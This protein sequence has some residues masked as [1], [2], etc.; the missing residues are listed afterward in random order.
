MFQSISLSVGIFVLSIAILV[1][2]QISNGAFDIQNIKEL[3]YENNI[4]LLFILTVSSISL[5]FYNSDESYKKKSKNK[6][7]ITTFKLIAKIIH[8]ST[9]I[10]V[11]DSILIDNFLNLEFHD[12]IIYTYIFISI[13]FWI[14][15]IINDFIM[16]QF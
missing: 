12:N 16:F 4:I 6:L 1:G 13:L 5:Y 8:I 11:V 2:Y 14:K 7:S 3:V 15:N 10:I 9:I